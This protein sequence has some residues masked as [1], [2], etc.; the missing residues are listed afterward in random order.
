MLHQ[1]GGVTLDGASYLYDLAGNRT[2]KTN[3]LTGTSEQYAYDSRYQP[4]QVMQGVLTT[5]SY[6]YNQV[7]NLS[8]EWVEIKGNRGFGPGTPPSGAVPKIGPSGG[9]RP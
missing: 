5:E 7:R 6:A 8:C 1:A 2:A 3:Q 9:G 4:T